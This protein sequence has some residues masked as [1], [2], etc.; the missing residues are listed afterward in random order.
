MTDWSMVPTPGER[1]ENMVGCQLL[2]YCHFREDTQGYRMELRYLRDVDRREVDFVVLRHRA[3]LFA[4]ECER[5]DR[6]VNP[7]MRIAALR[8]RRPRNRRA[9]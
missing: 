8:V 2:K 9:C 3:P 1:F 4:V 7:V 6:H 5:G